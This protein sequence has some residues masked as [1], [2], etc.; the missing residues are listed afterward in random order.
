[1]LIWCHWW[2]G[3]HRHV[4]SLTLLASRMVTGRHGNNMGDEC[5][6]AISK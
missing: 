4:V 1:M 3:H 2:Y 5:G 6:G